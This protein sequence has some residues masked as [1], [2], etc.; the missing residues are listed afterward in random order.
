[1]EITVSAYKNF[2][3]VETVLTDYIPH[4]EAMLRENGFKTDK[5]IRNQ[6]SMKLNQVYLSFTLKD[7][8]FFGVDLLKSLESTFRRD[9]LPVSGITINVRGSN[10]T[11]DIAFFRLMLNTYLSKKT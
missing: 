10:T 1:M 4:I 7:G 3:V 6:Q 2:K 5:L 9:G 8:V 11:I